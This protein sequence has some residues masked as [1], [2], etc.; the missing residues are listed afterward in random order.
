MS[1]SLFVSVHAILLIFLPT[2]SWAVDFVW[3]EGEDAASET[4]AY[5]GWYENTNIRKDL[6]S[7]GQ[8]EASDG[9]WLIHYT[10]SRTT[11]QATYDFNIAQS[12]SY[13]WWLR[14]NPFFNRNGG[15]VYK[16]SLDDQ[17]LQDLP[18]ADHQDRND[19]VE[20]GIDI[21]FIA[22][23]RVAVF[24]LSA[25]PH[26]IRVQIGPGGLNGDETHGGIDAM[27]FAT[28]GWAPA[29][30]LRPDQ[31]PS[32][33]GPADWFPLVMGPDSF[34]PESIIDMS[35]VIKK[36]AGLYGHIQRQA[37]RFVYSGTGAP[38]KFWGCNAEMAATP[39]LQQRQA[40][41]YAKH[42]INLVRQ[43]PV[44][45]V[46]GTLEGPVGNRNFDP[47]ALDRLDQWFATLKE[48]GI[49]MCWSIFYHHIVLPDEGVS[50]SLFNELPDSGPGKDTYGKASFIQEYQDSQWTYAN[51][52]LNHVNPYTG[53]V[54]KNDPALAIVEARNEDS[55]FFH[56]P[57]G[58]SFI[59]GT[60]APNHLLRLREMWHAWVATRYASDAELAAAWGAGR[61]PEDSVTADPV[62]Q[63]MYM[64][65]AWE[66]TEN[67]PFHNTTAERARMGD[68]I[69]FLAEMQRETYTTYRQRLRDIGYQGIVVSTG[70]K[71]GGP[72]AEAANLWTDDAADAIDRH[73]YF[74]GGAGGHRIATGTVNND[75]HLS[76]PGKGILS[77]G[78]EQVEDKPFIL[79]EWTQSPPNEWKA[80]IA[81]LYVF[82]GMGLQGWDGSMQFAG[83]RSAMGDGWPGMSSYV[84][85]TPHY[86]AQ[87]PALTF[88][89]YKWHIA[90]APFATARRVTVDE[91]FQGVAN[92]TIA[93]TPVEALA[94]GRV[95]AKIQD[96][97]PPSEIV[98][99]GPYWNQGAQ[100]V[101]SMTGDL[102]WDYGQ[103]VVTV[104]TPKTQGVI[105]FA[106][107]H[108]FDLPGVTV[109]IQ[110][111]FA[112]LIF[113]PLD[114]RPLTE[115][116]NILITAMARDRQLNAEYS[117]DG[118]ELL[119]TGGP[120]LYLE[121][122]RAAI[123]M[124]G[125]AIES[126]R[127]VDVYGV[128]AATEVQRS[129]NTFDIDG[130]YATY[131]YQ[132][133]RGLVLR[134]HADFDCDGDVDQDDF[135]TFQACITG[136]AN[137]PP[138]GDCD[139]ADFDSD[140][141]VDQADFG[142][143]QR[144]FSDPNDPVDP[145]CTH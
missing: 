56:N 2:R 112:S 34:S 110:T 42:G 96:G 19:L 49:Y 16:Y 123:T 71:A 17:G 119:K 51:L 124:K 36:P 73:A 93:D 68:F 10:S 102:T 100:S 6:L 80:E 81:P 90:E 142:L 107:G 116:N 141:D 75:T 65:A 76:Q 60:S 7:P 85:E 50:A 128:P 62:T 137:G 14:C 98:D 106:G 78:R 122:V 145:S 8:P 127:V 29:G 61:R 63:P 13:T 131:Y 64:Y 20:P 38:V 22:W 86:L 31:I 108:S 132:V 143:L 95:A 41:F 129:G 104:H 69:R 130:R 40:R 74:G 44:Q 99:L 11:G 134:Y 4:F 52:L 45:D 58:N 32:N 121:P 97:Q 39:Q 113:T 92:S 79:T 77:V 24:S 120:P 26:T 88:A 139:G 5:N 115:S 135:G 12:G 46:L 66:M 59:H 126:V 101:A 54:Y 9:A 53:L 15:G 35:G 109:D 125:C 83:H 133:T 48:N 67:G 118:T 30:V 55:V 91:I 140:N 138:A 23:V 87:F 25:G 27:C 89:I 114:D 33:P 136:P 57:L 94:V 144:C 82:Y 72:A 47:N 103:R 84:T 18:L 21:R 105:G 37:D 3:I 1:R 28:D 43:H 70:W 111:G 117:P